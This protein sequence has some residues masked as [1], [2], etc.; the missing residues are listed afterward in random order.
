MIDY[1]E[2][3]MG[4]ADA[5]MEQIR[6]MERSVPGLAREEGQVEAR[7]AGTLPRKEEEQTL[8]PDGKIETGNEKTVYN[9]NRQV[10]LTEKSVDNPGAQRK[11]QVEEANI[12]Q[13]QQGGDESRT[14]VGKPDGLEEAWSGTKGKQRPPLAVRLEK[15]ER[16]AAALAAPAG[17]RT[18][19]TGWEDRRRAGY[20][21]SLP[22]PLERAS[23]PN[24][25]GTPGGSQP[26]ENTLNG[27]APTTGGVLSWAEQ[28]DRA[29][30]RDSR[31]YDG[32][33]YL[34]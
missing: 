25:S 26:G 6:R 27:P 22:G 20:P 24:I 33:F 3:Q 2:E 32:G 11:I 7:A 10:N 21:V 13:S 9:L 14:T 17:G 23:Y 8:D 16:A 31:R 29:F 18:V 30:R 34:Y 28:A 4:G 12:G 1:L 15:L 19:Q 5:L